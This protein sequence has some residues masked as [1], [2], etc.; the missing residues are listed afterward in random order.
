MPASNAGGITGYNSGEVANCYANVSLGANSQYTAGASYAALICAFNSGGVI[1]NCFAMGS[2]NLTGRNNRYAG[3]IRATGTGSVVNCFRDEN[4]SVSGSLSG[5]AQ[6]LANMSK[7]TF[8]T[9]SLGW[10]SAIWYFGNVNLEDRVYPT[11]IQN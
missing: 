9:V 7:E 3:D 5:T 10:D 1:Q 8:Y 4:A 2:V 6:T 11:L